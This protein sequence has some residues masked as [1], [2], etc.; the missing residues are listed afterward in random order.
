MSKIKKGSP[1]N[2]MGQKMKVGQSQTKLHWHRPADHGEVAD[3]VQPCNT[4]FTTT[5]KFS[6]ELATPGS[7][8][9]GE[10]K[11]ARDGA[12]AIARKLA[13]LECELNEKCK[14]LQF[15]KIVNIEEVDS[16]KDLVIKATLEWMCV[17]TA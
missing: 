13:E 1:E 4:A 12:V 14:K 3:I 6:Q 2:A 7:P 9:V 10:V 16:D 8:T 5:G 17:A 15:V 11:E